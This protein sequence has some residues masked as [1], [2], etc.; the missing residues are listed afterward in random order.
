MRL[1]AVPFPIALEYITGNDCGIE[2]GWSSGLFFDRVNTP[3]TGSR[4]DFTGEVLGFWAHQPDDEEDDWH[5]FAVRPTNAAGISKV[6]QYLETAGGAAVGGVWV[7]V[8]CTLTCL[9]DLLPFVSGDCKK[10]VDKAV[11]DA[12]TAVHEG[13]ATVDGIFPGFGDIHDA[14]LLSGMGHHLNMVSGATAD[15]DDRPGLL[16]ESAGPIGKPDPVE[17]LATVVTDVIGTTVRYDR[18]NGP[19]Q[20]EITGGQD[21]HADSAP[22]EAKDWEFLSLPHTQFTPVDNLAFF[23]W[24][25]FREA[26]Q[27][28]VRALGWP[29]HAF[30]DAT[31]PMH[32]TATFGWGHR[33]YEDAFANRLDSYL[34]QG[35]LQGEKEQAERIIRRALVWRQTILDWRAAHPGEERDIP[36]RDLVTKLAGSTL[37]RIQGPGMLIWP[38]NVVMSADYLVPGPPRDSSIAFYESSPGADTVNRELLEEG[39]AAELAFLV[40]IAEV[41]P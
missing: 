25:K 1:G 17:L 29:L 19:K 6:K 24:K 5:L 37:E 23:G 21:F 9:A 31:V 11:K 18:S 33:P 35:D 20:Y 4:R 16:F 22:R 27:D 13:V 28:N 30:G 26:P 36:V 3:A 15:Y 2:P 32:V 14:S 39:I 40:S 8:R 10:C 12:K 38:F 7:T 41:L 34:F